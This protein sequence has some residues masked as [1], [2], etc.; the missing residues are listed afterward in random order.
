VVETLVQLL[1]TDSPLVDTATTG[2]M[3]LEKL[4]KH[5]DNLILSDLRMPETDGPAFYRP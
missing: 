3:A 4:Q 1:S 5:P 2:A